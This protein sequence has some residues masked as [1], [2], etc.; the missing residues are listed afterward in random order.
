MSELNKAELRER[1]KHEIG[2]CI[3]TVSGWDET[4]DKIMALISKP[5]TVEPESVGKII[6]RPTI[7]ELEKM[8]DDGVNAEI[9]PDGKVRVKLST[10]EA[11]LEK[12][13]RIIELYRK[14][15]KK[16]DGGIDPLLTVYA[17]EAINAIQSI[18]EEE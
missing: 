4:V 1:V 2:E 14:S 13:L 16:I 3:R 15:Y 5:S 7:A 18:V 17:S 11:K 8:L 6:D 10:A 12:V 9:L